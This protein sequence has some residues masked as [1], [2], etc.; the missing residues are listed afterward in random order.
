MFSWW[1]LKK[2]LPGLIF[3]KSN[4]WWLIQKLWVWLTF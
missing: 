1:N 4:T 3:V 2:T